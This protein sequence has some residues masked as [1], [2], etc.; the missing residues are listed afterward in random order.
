LVIWK[1]GRI[2]ITRKHLH[3]ISKIYRR[4]SYSLWIWFR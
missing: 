2:S 1:P 3:R 4:A